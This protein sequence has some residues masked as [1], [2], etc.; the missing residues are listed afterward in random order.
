MR[1]TLKLIALSLLLSTHSLIVSAEQMVVGISA[2]Q[3][4][5]PPILWQDCKGS[6]QGYA[7]LLYRQLSKSM[8]MELA[9]H[10]ITAEKEQQLDATSAALENGDF[11]IIATANTEFLNK[12]LTYASE[13]F[14]K[15]SLAIYSKKV[16]PPTS[17]PW[18]A[19][20]D[21]EGYWVVSLPSMAPAVRIELQKKVGPDTEINMQ[22]NYNEAILALDSGEIDYVVTRRLLGNALIEHLG[23][24]QTIQV[25]DL[26]LPIGSVYLGVAKNSQ[27][28]HRLDD[29]NTFL[30]DFRSSGMNRVMMNASMN[31]WLRNREENCNPSAQ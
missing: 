6:N 8:N 21:M 26:A 24:T 2:F 29:I 10:I 31:R 27:L 1:K 15:S 17:K 12:Q 16:L 5:L 28:I 23:I 20:N 19:L 4:A 11:N 9:G 18:L 14:I 7:A 13:P 25:T 3:E 22:F 30:K